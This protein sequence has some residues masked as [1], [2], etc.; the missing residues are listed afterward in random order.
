MVRS[1]EPLAAKHAKIAMYELMERAGAAAFACLQQA[2]PDAR[3]ILVLAGHGNN[4]GDGY[5][6]ARLAKTAGMAV[7]LYPV[8]EIARHTPDAHKAMQ[9]WLQAGGVLA[10]SLPQEGI[11]VVVD[12]MLG[13]GI[14]GTVYEPYQGLIGWLNQSRL[15]VLSLDLPSGLDAD[16][17]KPCGEAVWATHTVTFVGI[18]SGL[19]TGRGKGHC[20]QL[21]FADLGIGASFDA[22]AQACAEVIHCDHLPPL[23]RRAIHSHKGHHGKLLC[24]GG[25]PGLAGAMRLCAEAALRAGAGLVKVLC[26]PDGHNMVAYGRPEIM[27]A[28]D[29][30]Y[31][32]LFE[33][34][35]GFAIGPGLGQS[36]WARN[37]FQQFMRY[38]QAHS[39]PT[40]M[41][42]D[43]LNLLAQSPTPLS[44]A[45]LITP[46]PAEA[47]R[48]LHS[49]TG[50][51]E[52]DRY[53]ALVQLA[54][55][56]H[57]QVILKGAGSLMWAD[58]KTLVCG[59]GNPGMAVGGMGDIL[60]GIAAGLMVQGMPLSEV[61]KLAPCLHAKAADMAA[62]EHGERGMMA[63]DLLPY[64]RILVNR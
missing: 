6:L 17:G 58:N 30:N 37:L 23:P 52:A 19:V 31:T 14:R 8:G 28:G 33:W 51:V 18:K 50:Q 54:R 35:D 12:A 1:R 11:D 49:T 57:A 7:T 5:V 64:V 61:T 41:D 16:T 15:P 39:K 13:T 36:D 9:L 10:T 55:A 48:L 38:Q 29:H 32:E 62:G 21:H 40:V 34:A 20:G 59:D 44:S 27:L 42:A 22:L 47:A 4:G 25:G 53:G 26:H 56:F 43:A 24:I 45:V 2:F 60:T 63:T 46:H 3:R